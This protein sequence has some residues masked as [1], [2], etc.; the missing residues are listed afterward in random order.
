MPV[1]DIPGREIAERLAFIPSTTPT[2][3]SPG[4]TMTT[5]VPAA[6]FADPAP[7]HRLE[8][9][10]TALTAYG[11]TVE[12]LDD[13]AAARTRVKDLIP[14]GASVFTMHFVPA[15]EDSA[16]SGFEDLAD[17]FEQAAADGTPIREI[18][19]EDPVEFVEAFVQNYSEGGY[20]PTRGRKRLTDA[21][22]RAEEKTPR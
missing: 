4:G 13:A 22:A 1:H 17:L 10:A 12:I 6:L 19:G 8:R 5:P 9:A 18:L 14:E 20:V 2:T 3:T 15:D 7:A 16:A 21:T 11:F